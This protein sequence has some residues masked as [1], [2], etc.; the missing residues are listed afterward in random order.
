M[1]QAYSGGQQHMGQNDFSS[2]R[3]TFSSRN[4]HL[5]ENLRK[6]SGTTNDASEEPL[7]ELPYESQYENLPSRFP[8]HPWPTFLQ[9]ILDCAEG[10]AQRDMLFCGTLAALGATVSSFTFQHYSQR[11]Q[12]PNLQVFII[13]PAASG[14]G[15]ISWIRR[16]VMPFHKE[17]IAHYEA[18]KN[19]FQKEMR[20]WLNEGKNRDESLKPTPP[21]LELFFIAGNN[22]GTGIQENI[23][24]NDGF[25]LILEPEAEVLST[26]IQAEYGQWSHLLRKAHD[27]EF[28]SYNRRKDHEYR[29]CDLIRLSVVICGTPGQLTK[30]IP[31]AENGLFSR[32]VFY[33]MPPLNK[34]VDMFPH[35]GIKDYND[36]FSTWGARWKRV[37]D[38]LRKSV[39]TIEFVPTEVQRE[40]VLERWAQLFQ[41]ATVAHGDAMRNSVVRLAIN[42]LRLMNVMALIRSLNE[43]LTMEEDLLNVKLNN[44]TS[45]LLNCP[46]I[47][48]AGNIPAENIRDGIVSNFCLTVN[49]EDFEAL[50]LLAEPLYRHA[51]HALASMPQELADERKMTPQERF[52]GKLPMKFTR[53]EALEIAGSF[54]LTDKQCEY[55]LKKLI[56]SSRLEKQAQ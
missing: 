1:Q 27:H 8:S 13:A 11:K 7:Q 23:I 5:E 28:L 51:E 52:L 39:S 12:Y 25:G 21:R 43:L 16:L 4:K 49:D 10:D 22:S 9:Q 41:H 32:Q 18:A 14:K 48:P 55:S 30:L 24:E 29:E 46:G 40:R 50:L 42:L 2:N 45:T 19:I 34:F 56:E 38:A 20:E 33:F 35:N 17:K 3:G 26:A 47:S 36:L 44:I 54:G 53:Q 15:A 6:T 37:V 31:D